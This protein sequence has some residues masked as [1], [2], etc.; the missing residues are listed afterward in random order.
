MDPDNLMRNIPLVA[1]LA[2]KPELLETLRESLLQMHTNDMM[3]VVAMAASRLIERYI[4]D[5]QSQ[6]VVCRLVEQVIKDMK[7]P[8]RSCADALDLALCSHLKK[9][10]ESRDMSHE[11]A[12][13]KFGVS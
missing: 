6:D 5:G 3:I 4:L 7:C 9:V 10:L 12:S 8:D 1:L 2:G 11:D 13:M